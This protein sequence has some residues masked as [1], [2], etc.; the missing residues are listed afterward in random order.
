MP[1]RLVSVV[2][3]SGRTFGPGFGA[4]GVL[5]VAPWAD[6]IPAIRRKN[7]TKVFAAKWGFIPL[8]C[9]SKSPSSIAGSD[10][11]VKTCSN[12]CNRALCDL[13]KHSCYTALTHVI[14][15]KAVDPKRGENGPR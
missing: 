15:A 10:F 8:Y 13:F 9:G 1:I 4:E 3:L 7:A 14:D 5:V 11:D 12:I 2:T 6:A